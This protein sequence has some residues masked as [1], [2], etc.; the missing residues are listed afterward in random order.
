MP[1]VP[2]L[3][4]NVLLRSEETGGHVS[5]TEI[6]VPPHSAGPHC[7]GTTSTRPSTCLRR[8]DLPRR[9]RP[10]HQERGRALLRRAQRSPHAGQPQQRA[11]ALRARLHGRGLRAPPGAHRRRRGTDRATAVGAAADPRG[12]GRRPADRGAGVRPR[13]VSARR[14]RRWKRRAAT[15]TLLPT[16]GCERLFRRTRDTRR[17]RAAG[18]LRGVSDDR[19]TNKSGREPTSASNAR[20]S[21]EA[22]ARSRPASQ[23]LRSLMRAS[24]GVPVVAP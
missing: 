3:T 6:V 15:S 9:R 16:P 10:R 17:R 14:W 4:T 5:V 18:A 21:S 2:N 19:N 23:S 13:L 20:K 1:S 12:H 8:A 22:G 24:S 7:T 11:R